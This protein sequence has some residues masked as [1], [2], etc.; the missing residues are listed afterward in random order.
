M[1]KPIQFFSFFFAIILLPTLVQAQITLNSSGDASMLGNA[2]ISGT[3]KIGNPSTNAKMSLK[4]SSSCLYAAYIYNQGGSGVR[5]G[6]DSRVLASGTNYGVRGYAEFGSTN[7]GVV[8]EAI[9]GSVNYGV[10]G[11]ALGPNSYGGYFTGG[12]YVSG[13]ITQSSDERLKTNIEALD[14][15]DI[16]AKIQALN[17]RKYEFLSAEALRGRG[18]PAVYSTEG[19]HFGLLAQELESVFPELVSEVV[20]I[21]DEK[22]DETGKEPQTVTTK[23]INYSELTVVLLAAIQK[24][25]AEL[26]ALRTEVEALKTRLDG[27]R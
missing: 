11:N 16:A 4:C 6:L 22:T 17:P 13:G 24:Q 12:L 8:G 2:S 23:A 14:R 9:D 10:Q 21:L 27:K 7:R 26:E 5:Y 20:H 18:L 1:N 15:S 25:Q 19:T 3:L